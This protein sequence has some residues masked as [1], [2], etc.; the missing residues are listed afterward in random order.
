MLG[1]SYLRVFMGKGILSFGR[2]WEG[3][4]GVAMYSGVR[5]GKGVSEWKERLKGEI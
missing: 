2:G 3:L 5:E 1:G 4:E